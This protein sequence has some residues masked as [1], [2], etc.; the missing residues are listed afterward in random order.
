MRLTKSIFVP[1]VLA[2]CISYAQGQSASI[3]GGTVYQQIDG[4]GAATAFLDAIPTS[5]VNTLYS[6]SSIGLKYIRTHIVP[7]YSDCVSAYGSCVNVPSGAT[8]TTNDLA[9]VKAAVANGAV[10]W[11]TLWSPPG[12]MKDNGSFSS[13]GNFIGNSSNYT[14]LANI[15]TSWVTLMTG[16]YNI[17]VYAISVQNEPDYSGSYAS[18]KWTAQQI[19]DFVPYLRGALNAAGFSSTKIVI[20]EPGTWVNTY[21]A[22]AMADPSVASQV[23]ILASHGYWQSGAFG[24]LSYSNITN[25]HQWETEVSDYNTYD[26]GMASALTYAQQIHQLLSSAHLNSWNYWLISG[27]GRPD[28][29]GL[30]DSGNNVAKRAYMMGNWARFVTGMN[31]I[32]ATANPQSGVYITAF[33]NQSTGA[34]AIVAI[35]SNGGS[36]S[37]AFSLNGLSASSLTPYLTDANHNLTEQSPLTVSNGNATATLNGQSI[38][39]FVSSGDSAA[40]PPPTNLTSTAK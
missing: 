2:L 32:S 1:T 29:E 4:F 40:P 17:P 16:T 24:P 5:V 7:D 3:N 34:F 6:P 33:K 9:N 19:H 15:E 21:A 30:T 18:C 23:G 20:A 26:G 13:G 38:T 39:T 22:T 11:G 28:N 31:E 12:S 36:V 27:A 8:I 35:N 10:L 14:A 37:Q 25:Q